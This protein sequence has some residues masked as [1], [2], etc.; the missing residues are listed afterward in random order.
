MLCLRVRREAAQGGEGFLAV[1]AA[2]RATGEPVGVGLR[3]EL[4]CRWQG[5]R[6]RQRRP[7]GPEPAEMGFCECWVFSGVHRG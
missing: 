1:V 3:M 4:G 6:I 2:E 7:E 5:G